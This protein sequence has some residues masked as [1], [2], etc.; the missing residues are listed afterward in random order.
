MTPSN[1]SIV[2]GNRGSAQ[3][4]VV[5]VI[6]LI[7]LL[8]LALIIVF[9][10]KRQIDER[11][12]NRKISQEA[13]EYGMMMALKRIESDPSWHEGFTNVKYKDGYYE[14]SIEN[15]TDSLFLAK[16]TGYC[17]NLKKRVICTYHLLPDS[18]GSL[19]PK[20]V[21]WEYQ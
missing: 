16:A 17:N 21:G 12:M 5:L 2:S 20:T 19:R 8:A 18:T 15:G 9:I 6:S 4:N 13:A 3:S 14:V 11:T 10:V 7:T 1:R